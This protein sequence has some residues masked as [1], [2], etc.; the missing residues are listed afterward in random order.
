MIKIT[1]IML[2]ALVLTSTS[3]SAFADKGV[4]K[5]SKNKVALNITTVGSIKNSLAFNLK[6]GLKYT[7]SFLYKRPTTTNTGVVFNS[8][9]VVTYQK[10]N[11][12]YIIPYKQKII[13][14]ELKQG[15]AGVK[16][17]IPTH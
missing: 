12:V 10:G 14:P 9:T 5:K 16:I 17:I 4:G 13:M 15:Y 8:R 6:S 2:L 11:T 3:Y 7:G 1:K